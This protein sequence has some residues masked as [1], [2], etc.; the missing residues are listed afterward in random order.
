ML[1]K[2]VYLDFESLIPRVQS[3][4]EAEGK[5]DFARTFVPQAELTINDQLSEIEGALGRT[6]S[7]LNQRIIDESLGDVLNS[8]IQQLAGL[9]LQLAELRGGASLDSI[10]DQN[11]ELRFQLQ[12]RQQQFAIER[13]LR[14]AGV[15]DPVAIKQ[16]QEDFAVSAR[17]IFDTQQELRDAENRTDFLE[18][19]QQRY[20]FLEEELELRSKLIGASDQQFAAALTGLQ[21]EQEARS[22]NIDLLDE[23]IQK[24]IEVAKAKAQQAQ[25]DREVEDTARAFGAASTDAL[26]DVSLGFSSAEE[27]ASR[28]LSRLG[29]LILEIV[30]FRQIENAL[31]SVFNPFANFLTPALA[32]ANGNAFGPQGLIPFANG[33]VVDTP[34]MFG[35]GRGQTGVMGEAG[36]EAIL[37]LERGRDGKLGVKSGG[38]GANGPVRAAYFTEKDLAAA[39]TSGLLDDA[40]SSRVSASGGKLNQAVR[41]L[42]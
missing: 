11:D 2:A 6:Q 21:L 19:L 18:G 17:A 20:Q 25:R 42:R 1:L 35:F 9:E 7:V 26:R 37:P 39:I 10:R 36:P 38:G 31:T 34:T 13:E 16:A 32:S 8:Q 40:M 23:E 3:A 5:I 4:L 41:S 30:I 15:N 29:E 33:G 24:E 27:A 22:R 14:T 12:L 28:L